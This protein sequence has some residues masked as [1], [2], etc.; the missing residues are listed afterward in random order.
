VKTDVR[1]TNTVELIAHRFRRLVNAVTSDR[2]EPVGV[3]AATCVSGLVQTILAARYVGLAGSGPGDVQQYGLLAKQYADAGATWTYSL[4]YVLVDLSVVKPSLDANWVAASLV[5]QG[6]VYFLKGAVLVLV[7]SLLGFRWP[8][9]LAVSLL[10]GTATAFPWPGHDFYSGT[11]P[12]NTFTSI[13]QSLSTVAIALVVAGLV[14][15]LRRPDIGRAA[16]LGAACLLLALCKP[17]W[18]PGL[19]LA[20]AI[21]TAWRCG[22]G[23]DLRQGASVAILVIAPALAVVLASYN[24]TLGSSGVLAGRELIWEPFRNWNM[25]SPTPLGD[26]VRAL[27]FP[28]SALPALALAGWWSSHGDESVAQRFGLARAELQALIVAWIAFL[29]SLGIW[30][31][32]TEFIPGWGYPNDFNLAWGLESSVFALNLLSALVLLRVGTSAAI[33]PMLVLFAQAATTV[34]WM[35]RIF[36]SIY[37]GPA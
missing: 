23:R 32:W 20:I 1:S 7:V 37:G 28:L 14:V 2:F 36:P 19:V 30:L 31:G 5:L 12:G 10:V 3:A 16:L 25:W 35:F 24:A 11:F 8:S 18:V 15:Y 13:T 17:S 9:A 22:H 4:W 21:V 6:S 27:A 34:D 33:L 29:V 26:L